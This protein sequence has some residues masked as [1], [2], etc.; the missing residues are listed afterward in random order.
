MN[1]DDSSWSFLAANRTVIS[2]RVAS[3]IRVGTKHSHY[4]GWTDTH[5]IFKFG[6]AGV[7]LDLHVY[8]QKNGVLRS[9]NEGWYVRNVEVFFGK[10][11]KGSKRVDAAVGWWKPVRF[12]RARWNWKEGCASVEL[13]IEIRVSD[14]TVELLTITVF[15]KKDLKSLITFKP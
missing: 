13:P 11:P 15:G 12:A 10:V 14:G 9:T 1:P 8:A 4:D 5:Q 2:K 7:D 3:A 6:V